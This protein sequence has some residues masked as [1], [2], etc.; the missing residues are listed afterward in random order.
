MS[1]TS[2]LKIMP[3][4]SFEIYHRCHTRDTTSLSIHIDG[5]TI[6]TLDVRGRVKAASGNDTVGAFRSAD[7]R[8]L[9]AWIDP[10]SGKFITSDHTVYDSVLAIP[11]LIAI[12]VVATAAF[13]LARF[14]AI[15]IVVVAVIWAIARAV[16]G[17][18]NNAALELLLRK[19]HSRLL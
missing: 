12:G 9:V 5:L 14:V 6:Y 3:I 8:S 15:P 4:G 10:E 2:T 17:R 7:K 11:V 18:K 1:E 19:P 16:R 13:H